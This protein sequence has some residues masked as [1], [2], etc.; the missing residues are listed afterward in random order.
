MLLKVGHFGKKTRSLWD[1]FKCPAGAGWIRWSGRV[2]NE[3]FHGAK[4]DRN[5]LLTVK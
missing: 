2:R 4:E 5:I 1:V 3:V